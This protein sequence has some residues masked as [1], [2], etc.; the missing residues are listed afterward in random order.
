MLVEYT[1]SRRER[2]KRDKMEQGYVK[3]QCV[4]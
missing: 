3:Y 1:E 2:S 4:Q